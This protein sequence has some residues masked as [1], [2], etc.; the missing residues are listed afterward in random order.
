VYDLDIYLE[1]EQRLKH[2][3]LI[4]RKRNFDKDYALKKDNIHLRTL[5]QEEFNKTKISYRCRDML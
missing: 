4:L 1:L 2:D 3:I 5:R